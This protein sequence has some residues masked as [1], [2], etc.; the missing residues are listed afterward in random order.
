MVDAVG[1]A[2]AFEALRSAGGLL[3]G[4]KDAA[5]DSALK[6]RL[7]EIQSKVLDAQQQ[8]GDAQAE[9]L[10]LL[11]QLA[12]LKAKIRDLEASKDALGQYE[13]ADL[14]E[15]RKAYRFAGEGLAHYACPSCFSGGK[16]V[17]LQENQTGM[18]QRRYRCRVC[19]FVETIG[20]HDPAEPIPSYNPFDRL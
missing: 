10:D 16:V 18:R 19:Q 15:G 20:P 13:L 8:L 5:V 3:K 14:G 12:A 11:E 17:V 2:A 7:I 4:A 6:D 9:R 1:I